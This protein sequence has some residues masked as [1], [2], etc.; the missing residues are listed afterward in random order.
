MPTQESDPEMALE[1]APRTSRVYAAALDGGVNV[2]TAP[3]DSTEH[4]PLDGANVACAMR[5]W[6][7]VDQ[8]VVLAT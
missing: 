5:I 6:L 3:V 4:V 2:R 8:I 1:L 7:S